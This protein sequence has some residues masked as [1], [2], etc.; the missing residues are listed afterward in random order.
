MVT[1]PGI[2]VITWIDTHL[3]TLKRQKVW[4]AWLVEGLAG[5]VG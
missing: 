1:T 5:L 2:H 4:L 3:L